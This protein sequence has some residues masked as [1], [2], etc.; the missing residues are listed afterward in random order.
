MLPIHQ[1]IRRTTNGGTTWTTVSPITNSF[2]NSISFG[3]AAVA[4]AV[5]GGG[6]IS[7]TTNG[8]TNWTNQG[9]TQTNEL[10]ECDFVDEDHGWAVGASG[11]LL[12][13]TNAGDTWTV[14]NSGTTQA[15][16]G[17]HFANTNEGWICG[18]SGTIRRTTDGG[19]NW[20]AQ[21]SP[22][23]GA[24]NAVYFHS[25]TTGW[26]VG[27]SGTILK[28]VNGGAIWTAQ[29]SGTTLTLNNLHFI[30][31]DTGFVCGFGGVLLKTT[32]AGNTW[33]PVATGTTQTL[34]SVFFLHNNI[35]WIGGGGVNGLLRKTTDGGATWVSQSAN[36]VVEQIW[37]GNANEGWLI[38]GNTVRATTNGGTTWVDETDPGG[39][40]FSD[41]EV[42]GQTAWIVGRSNPGTSVWK[43]AEA[44]FFEPNETRVVSVDY[45]KKAFAAGTQPVQVTL[46]NNGAT[47][48]NSVQIEWEI[49]GV[50]Q[51]P[52]SWAGALL[53][54]TALDSVTIGSAFF[55]INTPYSIRAWTTQ[56]NG[57]PDG[58]VS[59]DTASVSN[60]YAALGGNYTL[61]GANPDF[62]TFASAVSALALGGVVDSV[63]FNIRNGTYTEQ[64]TLKEVF[65]AGADK[66]ITFQS[67][68]GDS[69][70]VKLTFNS[71][72]S[73]NYTLRIDSADWFR[74]RRMTLEATNGTYGRVV[75]LL[76]KAEN[77][78][79][80]NCVLQS[81]LTGGNATDVFYALSGNNNTA[82][83]QNRFEGGRIAIYMSAGSIANP[84]IQDNRFNNQRQAVYLG[85]VVNPI[86]SGNTIVDTSVNATSGIFLIN[87]SNSFSIVNNKIR[88]RVGQ[89][90]SIENSDS[91]LGSEGLIANNFVSIG[92][93][94]ATAVYGIYL[95]GSDRVR[96]YH[97]NVNANSSSTASRA[98][99]NTTSTGLDARNNI[100]A[101]PLGAMPVQMNTSTSVTSNYNDFYTTGGLI[102]SWQGV[103]KATLADWQLA[104]GQ[105]GNSRS[106]NPQFISSTDL[107][108]QEPSLN[109]AGTPV[110]GVSDDIDRELRN[111]ATPDIGADEFAPMTTR[112]VGVEVFV[113]PNKIT[114]FPPSLRAVRAV[115]KNNGIDTIMTMTVEWRVNNVPKTPYNWA[116][117]LYPGERDTVVIGTQNIAIGTAY[118]LLA[119]TRDPDGFPDNNP[120]NDTAKLNDLY[121]GLN[122]A[123]TIGGVV[124]NFATFTAAVTALNKGGVLGPVQFNVRNGTYNEALTITNINGSSLA[125]TVTFQSESGDSSLVVLTR[126]SGGT[127]VNLDKTGNLIFQKMT[128][129]RHSS[130]FFYL[131][132]GVTNVSFLN[133]LFVE[134]NTSAS[135]YI[136]AAGSVAPDSDIKIRNNRFVGG[137]R[138]IA[139]Y[140]DNVVSLENG[141]RIENNVFSETRNHCIYLRYQ[142]A[143]VIQDNRISTSLAAYGILCETC[144]NGLR[145]TGNEVIIGQNNRGIRLYNCTGTASSRA[146]VANNI[147]SIGGTLFVAGIASYSGSYQSFYHNSVNI[148]NTNASSRALELTGGG[149]N[150]NILN[151]IFANSG[152][153]YACYNENGNTVTPTADFNDLYA[154]GPNLA[155]WD[156]ANAGTLAVLR[157]LSGREQNSV[158][159]NPL[160][161]SATDLHVLQVAL[162][163]A[164]SFTPDVLTDID[165]QLRNT[166]YPDIGADEF[167]Y[168]TEDVG[169]T[170]LLSPVEQCDLGAAAAVKVVIQN[171]GGLPQTG[172]DVVYRRGYGAFVVENIGARVVQPGDTIHYT[173]AQTTNMSAY[174]DHMLTL[175]TALAGDLNPPNDTLIDWVANYQTPTVVANM[176]PAD[177]T[178]NVSPP[179]SFS[180]L[181]SS[182]A[183]RYDIYIWKADE[184]Q[185]ATPTGADLTQISY[186]HNPG[187]LVYGAAY[188]WQVVAKN[189]FCQTAGPTQQFTLRELPDLT[190]GSTMAPTQPFSGT[191]ISV[192]WQTTNSGSGATGMSSWYDYVYLSTDNT[193]QPNVDVYIGGAI[194]F[195][196]L[197]P[198]QSYAQ[199][200]Q[201]TLPQGIQGNYFLIVRTDV[202]AALPES[203]ENNNTAVAFP[204]TINLT[205]PPDLQVIAVIAP[206]NAFSGQPININWTVKNQGSGDML[207]NN[208]FR[209]FVYLSSS[210]TLNL[211]T[212]TL[213]GTYQGT[214]L[215]AGASS[216]RM[217]SAQLPQAV[218]G[219]YY[220]HVYTDRENDV[221][222]FAFEDN[223]IGVSDT[224]T[225]FLTPPPDLVV[226]SVT[227]PAF[228]SNNQTVTL[229]WTVENQGATTAAGNW[230]DR[231][232]ISK[233]ATYKPDSVTTL[234]SFSNPGN[235]AAGATTNR[236]GSV[237]IPNNIGGPY[238]FYVVTDVTNRVFEY[239]NE[240]NNTRR[241]TN[242]TDV[243][244]AD[245]V[246]PQVAAPDTAGSGT[247]IPVQWTVKNEGMGSL[248]NINRTDQIYLSQQSVLDI[249]SA[250]V[251]GGDVSG[252]TLLSAQEISRQ[253]NVVLPNGISGKYYV[254]VRADAGNTVFETD[255]GNNDNLDSMHINLSPWPDLL[256]S[257][258]DALP[259]TLLAGTGLPFNYTVLNSGTA[260]VTGSGAWKDR[261]YI[262][263]DSVFSMG[264][265]T[266]L[267]TLDILQPIPVGGSYSRSA[268]LALPFAAPQTYYLFVHTDADNSIYEY[269][270]D[271]NNTLRSAPFFLNTPSPVDFKNLSVT[272]LPDTVNSGQSVSLTWCVRNIGSSTAVFDF[273]LW[274]DGVYL[275]TDSIWDE[276]DDIFVKDFTKNGPVD[277]LEMYML[278]HTFNIPNGLSGN[279]YA[280]LVADHN[281]RTNDPD[282]SNNIKFVRPA[283]FSTGPAQPIHIQLS[284]SPDLVPMTFVAPADAYAGQP[285][286]VIWTVKNQ[287]PGP[288]SANWTDKIYL[289]TDFAIGGN[290]Q[291]VGTRN[292]NRVLAPGVQYSDT[293]E[294]FIPISAVGNYVLIFAT[295]ANNALFEFNG[296]NNNTFFTFLS[297]SLPDPSDLT[298]TDIEFPAMAVVGQSFRLPGT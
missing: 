50:A 203:N 100:F 6:I 237:A 197:N 120:A 48:L 171:F 243:L 33:T 185:P 110:A 297:T 40:Q 104:S 284:P 7:K 151:N 41:F 32:D 97:N 90:I 62:P 298:V 186:Y 295:D 2:F 34:E 80:E 114:P 14:G 235:L 191:S 13:T 244:N 285:I 26:I 15:L 74:F 181:P 242:P 144:N 146:L 3:T 272:T 130:D 198:G 271:G 20:T 134:T 176:L 238:Y 279:F 199:M 275:S 262:S 116:G 258:L 167:D 280:F 193:Y 89:G 22:F 126:Q 96:V 214:P 195:T 23:T 265:A 162:D 259:D 112:D 111:P 157:N 230:T 211:N 184:A 282:R 122:G 219:D 58:D 94:F 252:G 286:Q 153:G 174:K 266:L 113:E 208:N 289:S 45:P 54:G 179:V 135:D 148:T 254:H 227:G 88:L 226:N 260:A 109:N 166:N 124:P 212:A 83:V 205:P 115:L 292:Q 209:D 4:W 149:T 241:S 128:F 147:V 64:I 239:L 183:T 39:F 28:T 19:L 127:A 221:F 73:A 75:Y 257:A 163:S 60:L 200:A 170:R 38:Y 121:A 250:T 278:T 206:T 49:N 293:M 210:P 81:V 245:L 159:A 63:F 236:S 35:G 21:T 164:A 168:L 228:A 215:A 192:S 232:L 69:T 129:R 263:S 247:S 11:M 57:L 17:V 217:L 136:E 107:H 51:P 172:F 291:T 72:S 125:N 65:G 55:E 294:V 173:F 187:N 10:L 255:D 234:N 233:A 139:L 140:G 103:S 270:F 79:F 268:T 141:T 256:V 267:T 42:A 213:L 145:I 78:R 188:N 288:T 105:D 8:G 207:A 165:G 82:F 156:G 87:C 66:R 86:I 154:T 132:N 119:Y 225:I 216:L 177:G 248:L 180:W 182:G 46:F 137:Y 71:P 249:G 150:K 269:N 196:A 158:S 290:D 277:S 95:N 56:P 123:Y 175:F 142:N 224:L 194:N 76:N 220:I 30:N 102:G 53:V 27:N 253:A 131:V 37:F 5:G 43:R 98:L 52:F 67:E 287:G 178:T 133:N 44:L 143:P 201:V 92:E 155:Y 296:E 31:A 117:V 106:I 246:V 61:G 93:G 204:I 160:F 231:V 251:L 264:S 85:T 229:Q 36:N 108:I 16:I 152:G 70:A 24:L 223:N 281:E 222:E 274:Y 9:N 240:N 189:D 18:N 47:T 91:P 218:F 77:N 84:L 273:P 261:I 283:S 138:A 101:C 25:P 68:S 190:V 169:I 276:Y 1:V 118:N 29:T 12:Y 161:Y 202:N 99:Y 59:N